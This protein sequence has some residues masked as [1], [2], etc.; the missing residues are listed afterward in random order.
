[1][2]TVDLNS[3]LGESFGRYTIGNDEQVLPLITSANV[4]CGFHAGDPSV[5]AKTVAIAQENQVAVGAHPGYPDLNGFGRRKMA[6][7]PDDVTNMITYQVGALAAFTAGHRLHHVKPH[8]ALY[9][10]AGKDLALAI[11]I[12]KGIKRVDAQLPIYGLSGSNLIKAAAEVGIPSRSEAF[13][14]RAY[15][16]DG[17]LVPRSQAGAVLTD[18]QEVAERAVRM[19]KDQAVTAITGEKVALKVD[20]LCV[21]G[22]NAAALAIVKELRKTLKADSIALRAC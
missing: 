13:A 16:A 6:M 20:S 7:D 14:D 18:P 1:M 21:H 19:I 8:G 4:A 5:M 17:S 12:C 9:N 11:A 22:D 2:L 10:A 3:D 15:Q